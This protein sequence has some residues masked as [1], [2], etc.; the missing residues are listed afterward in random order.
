MRRLWCVGGPVVDQ[1][2]TSAMVN[3]TT[4]MQAK[5]KFRF[6]K[7]SSETGEIGAILNRAPINKKFGFMI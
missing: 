2:C 3:E 1:V 6:M 7:C 5:A 4:I